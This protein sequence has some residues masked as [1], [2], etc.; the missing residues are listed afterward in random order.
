LSLKL[1]LETKNKAISAYQTIMKMQI[2]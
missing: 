1:A 2:W